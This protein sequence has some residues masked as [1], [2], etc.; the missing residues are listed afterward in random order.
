[1]DKKTQKKMGRRKV[2]GT[3]VK[4]KTTNKKRIV[5]YP[6]ESKK[7][8]QGQINEILTIFRGPKVM[9][10]QS[11]TQWENGSLDSDKVCQKKMNV[12]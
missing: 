3:G 5:K 9:Q 6:E 4:K 1:M 11:V 8:A 10:Q 7:K 2:L 12:H